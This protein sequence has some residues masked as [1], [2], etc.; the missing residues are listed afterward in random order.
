MLFSFIDEFVA[1]VTLSLFAGAA[2]LI[3]T[4]QKRLPAVREIVG[5]QPET[6]QFMDIAGRKMRFLESDRWAANELT[7]IAERWQERLD[8]PS[9]DATAPQH[10]VLLPARNTLRE[11]VGSD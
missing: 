3:L 8:N 1:L 11:I 10:S 4:S 7:A 9:P 2:W 5:Y 6:G